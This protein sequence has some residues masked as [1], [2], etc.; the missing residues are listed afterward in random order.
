L[1]LL[2]REGVVRWSGSGSFDEDRY[3]EL[4]TAVEALA[5]DTEKGAEK[6]AKKDPAL[7]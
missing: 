7:N 4:F 6:G 2:D 3:H 5:A 1:V